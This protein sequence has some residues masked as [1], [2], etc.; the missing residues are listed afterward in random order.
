MTYPYIGAWRAFPFSYDLQS[1]IDF[2]RDVMG[3]FVL[4]SMCCNAWI[5]RSMC[6]CILFAGA[7]LRHQAIREMLT[8]GPISTGTEPYPIR[9][10]FE[11]GTVGHIFQWRPWFMTLR[12]SIVRVG[13][14]GGAS[15]SI[16]LFEIWS[17]RGY[18]HW[19]L[20]RKGAPAT[21]LSKQ[22]EYHAGLWPHRCFLCRKN[23]QDEI[24]VTWPTARKTFVWW[25]RCMFV[26]DWLLKSER[27]HFR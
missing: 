22:D 3:L 17:A 12:L 25:N 16:K 23:V 7:F 8:L 11:V 14:S 27:P 15:F 2:N 4:F 5:S 24:G 21:F 26:R 20:W 6:A 9:Y 10:F 13:G 19:H 18:G 1:S